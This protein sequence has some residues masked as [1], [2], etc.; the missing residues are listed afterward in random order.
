[1]KTK[2][3]VNELI[4]QETPGCLWF[5]GLFFVIIG[6]MLV[7]G[8]LGGFSNWNEVPAWQL[9]L[10]F[11]VAVSVISGGIWVISGA[12]ITKIVINRIEDYV[13]IKKYGF[14]GKR[15]TVYKFSEIK[16]FCLIEEKDSENDTIWS[17][18]MELNDGELLKTSSMPLH[19]E[20]IQRKYIF[21][22]NE[23]MR[24]QMPSYNSDLLE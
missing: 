8:T 11:F 7:Y 3:T 22:I 15:E 9:I 14:F 24:K 10:A 18:G 17:V 1:M 23:F 20:E 16:Q 6:G 13:L 4:I 2:Q 21:E 19:T 5:F 12:P